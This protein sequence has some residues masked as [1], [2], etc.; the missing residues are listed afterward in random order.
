MRLSVVLVPVA[1]LASACGGE[2][3]PAPAP[4]VPSTTAEFINQVWTSW[5]DSD[6][7]ETCAKYKEDPERMVASM[8]PISSGIPTEEVAA[9]LQ[10]NC[11]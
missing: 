3:E 5:S 11:P 9:L 10:K 8:F 2:P 6:R 4:A 7:A 1:L